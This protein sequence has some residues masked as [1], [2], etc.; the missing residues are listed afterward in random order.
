MFTKWEVKS[1]FRIT[2]NAG[3]MYI[4][5]CYPYHE[6]LTRPRAIEAEA[7]AH[8]IVAAVN[9]CQEVNPDNPMAVAENIQDVTAKLINCYGILEALLNCEHIPNASMAHNARQVMYL[10]NATLKHIGL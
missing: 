8:L 2:A 10:A 5:D 1:G 9:A 6:K 4:A 7:N 3:L